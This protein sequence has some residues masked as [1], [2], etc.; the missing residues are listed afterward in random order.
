MLALTWP[1]CHSKGLSGGW[2][3]LVWQSGTFPTNFLSL[4]CFTAPETFVIVINGIHF[5][6]RIPGSNSQRVDLHCIV[7]SSGSLQYPPSNSKPR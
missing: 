1:A 3:R 2:R 4:L 6:S 7:S 5:E